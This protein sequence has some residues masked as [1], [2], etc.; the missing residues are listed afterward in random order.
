MRPSEVMSAGMMPAFDLPGEATPGQ[1]GPTILVALPVAHACA[2]NSAVSCTGTPSVITTAS[3]IPASMAS[4]TADLVPAGGTKMTDTF[5]PVLVIASSPVPKTGTSRP[6]SS[7]VWPAFRGFV[8]PT[9]FAPAAIMR[10]PCLL[11]SDP[12]MPCTMILL[13]A[14]RKI[15][16]SCS[17]WGRGGQLGGAPRR[18]VHRGHLLDDGN[19]RLVQDA[20]ALRRPVAVQPDH[21]RVPHRRAMLGQQPDR[22]HDAVGHRVARGD[23][24]EH[25]HQHALD[26]R[27]RQH[28]LQA[29]GHDFS[30][31]AAADVQEVGGPDAAELLAGVGDDVEGGH[32]QAGPVS[33]DPDFALELHV[34]QVLGLGPRLQRIR[35]AR[36]REPVPVLT[37][38]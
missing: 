22:G 11:P 3:G 31:S 24:A 8:P 37:E 12:V 21:D 10:A 32:H 29:V 30:R 6:E 15:A 27:V 34:V 19:G 14:V 1:F 16:M 28:D 13:S 33:D 5:A 36:V 20:A 17:R 4:T 9:T 25:V 18:I 23:A 35:R 2:Q 7:M 38:G 26:A